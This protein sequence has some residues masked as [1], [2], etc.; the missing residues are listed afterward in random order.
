[1]KVSEVTNTVL[2]NYLRIDYPDSDDLLE[3]SN[4]L[5]NVKAYIRSYTG[6]D[7][8]AIDECEDITDALFIICADRY[9]NRNLYMDS[10]NSKVNK[11]V[12]CILGMHSI[13]LL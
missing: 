8:S 13:N 3:L 12:E 7:D 6:L 1:M 11:A 5:T 9:D 4:I 2:A 10:K